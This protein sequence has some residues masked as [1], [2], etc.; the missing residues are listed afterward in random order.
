VIKNGDFTLHSG[1]LMNNHLAHWF[2]YQ[3]NMS[4]SFKESHWI[5][6]ESMSRYT[7]HRDGLTKQKEKLFKEKN[8]AKWGIPAEDTRRAV[9]VINDAE[10][11]FAM[12]LP[13]ETKK[14]EYLAEEAAFFTNQCYKEARRVVMQDY[15]LG[16]W[17]FVDLGE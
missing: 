13:A 4:R 17:Q 12:M 16:R 7:L 5:R 8:V 2:K 6:S 10:L 1:E 9:D 15:A 14:G 3:K 11:A